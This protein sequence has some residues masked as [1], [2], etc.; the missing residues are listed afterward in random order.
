MKRLDTVCQLAA[1]GLLAACAA[2]NSA[3][4]PAGPAAGVAAGSGAGSGAR[5]APP[6][7]GRVVWPVRQAQAVMTDVAVKATVT[8]IDTGSNNS[9]ASTLSDANGEFGLGFGGGFAPQAGK[10]YYVEAYKGLLN[11]KVGVDAARVRTVLKFNA[12]IWTPINTGGVVIV[13]R[14]TTALAA[15][16]DLKGLSAEQQDQL[17][18]T[19][20]VD[21]DPPDFAAAG[22]AVSATEYLD[23]FDKVT[24][25]L[26]ADR[27]P[28]D[29]LQMVGG[30]LALREGVSV[31]AP[32]ITEVVPAQAVAGD[33][34]VLFGRYFDQDIANNVLHFGN[35]TTTPSALSAGRLEATVPEGAPAVAALSLVTPAGTA[36][37]PFTLLPKMPGSFLGI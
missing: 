33:K 19:L 18:G 1:A 9:V 7:V 17:I 34:V 24:L 8:F 23:A 6:V 2:T 20:G 12:G 5:S 22:T 32:I 11:N 36:S 3:L 27:D 31:Q 15:L 30:T 37:A 16:M 28:L 26:T 21:G 13:S 14:A 4:P 10:L 35:V 29:S 25:A